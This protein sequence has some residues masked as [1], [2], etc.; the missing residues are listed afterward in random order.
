MEEDMVV[1]AMV[2]MGEAVVVGAE[3]TVEVAIGETGEVTGDLLEDMTIIKLQLD[4]R[5]L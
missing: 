3:D 4:C 2:D 1:V 5:I